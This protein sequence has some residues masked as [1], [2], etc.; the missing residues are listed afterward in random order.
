MS[1]D[2]LNATAPDFH[3]DTSGETPPPAPKMVAVRLLKNYRPLVD[4][5]YEIVGYTEE[6]IKKKNSA[7]IIETIRPEKFIKNELPPPAQAGTGFDT[8][9]WAGAVIKLPADEAKAIKKAGIAEYELAD[10]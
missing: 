7:G 8:K 6:A 9:L 4:G 2:A 5:G 10:D 1:T 3:L